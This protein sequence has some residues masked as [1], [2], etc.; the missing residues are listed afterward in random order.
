M[1]F[2]PVSDP[3]DKIASTPSIYLD[4]IEKRIESV[5]VVTMIAI[6]VSLNRE[7]QGRSLPIQKSR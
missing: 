1:S 5:S 4:Q 3:R 2:S 7:S 6:I